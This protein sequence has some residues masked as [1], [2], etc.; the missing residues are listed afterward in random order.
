MIGV[1]KHVG[2]LS[3]VVGRQS[4]KEVKK[5]DVQLVDESSVLVRLTLWGNDVSFCTSLNCKI[6]TFYNLR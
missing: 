1:V 4:N 5:R 6:M 3:T 2:D